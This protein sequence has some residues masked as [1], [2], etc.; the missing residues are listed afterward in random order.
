MADGS[1]ILD[2]E[3]RD[4]GL[5]QTLTQA[6]AT[7]L[8]AAGSMTQLAQS[9]TQT[10][11]ASNSSSQAAYSLLSAL[12][13]TAQGARNLTSAFRQQQS[14]VLSAM[15]TMVSGAVSIARSGTS[16]LQQ[17]G[18]LWGLA[19]TNGLSSGLTGIT[20]A[21]N[22]GGIAAMNPWRSAA[23][24]AATVGYQIPAA[25]AQGIYNGNPAVL[26][27][28]SQAANMTRSAFSGGNWW[29]LGYNISAGVA[30]GVSGGSYLITSAAKSA[31]QSA[32]SA[33]KRALGVRSPSRV[34]RDEVGRM[35]P[36]GMALG[37]ADG[38]G[39]M[40]QAVAQASRQL[41]DLSR[42]T[43]QPSGVI[44]A[45]QTVVNC[46]TIQRYQNSTPT[47][48]EAPIY[49]DGREIARATAQY[50][51]RQMAYLEGL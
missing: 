40:Q 39:E 27:A 51:A 16:Q 37:I 11:I 20:A 32:L 9:I 48:F 42:R 14:G 31:A 23:S 44:P 34:F 25:V 13:L 5:T 29:S 7:A 4:A 50:T 28:S 22:S 36:A 15:S 10:K 38:A 43:L 45:A 2:I 24:T 1:I 35:I 21:S 6:R 26:S 30:S 3:A 18:T 41:T 47:V 19:I 17:A 49:L 46:T 8:Q 33:A 12:N